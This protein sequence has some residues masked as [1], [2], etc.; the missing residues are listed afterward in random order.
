MSTRAA[1][2]AERKLAWINDTLT[3]MRTQYS[4][5]EL[6]RASDLVMDLEGRAAYLRGLLG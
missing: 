4:A 5:E 6:E 3:F 1:F 2:K